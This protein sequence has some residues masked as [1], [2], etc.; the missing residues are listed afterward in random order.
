MEEN[1]V[2]IFE[3]LAEPF[4]VDYTGHL[5]LSVIGNHLLNCAGMHAD[6]RGFGITKLN[7]NNCTWVLSRIVI[8]FEEFPY[9]YEKFSIETWV[10]SVYKL[11]TNRNFAIL[12]KDG[13]PIGYA[14][15]IWAMIDLNTRKPCDLFEMHGGNITEYI[16]EGKDCPIEGPSRI[17]IKATEPAMSLTAKYSDIDINRHFN[18]VRYIEHILDL[19]PLEKFTETKLHRFEIAF[20]NESHYGD[21]LEYYLDDNGNNTYSVEVKKKDTGEIVCRSLVSFK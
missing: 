13:E 9:Q 18:S 7:D 6:Q 14:R 19:F 17:K 2:G 21:T 10:E 20:I 11:F 4:L 5:T 15:S 1:K 3:F 8:E 16:L 12:N